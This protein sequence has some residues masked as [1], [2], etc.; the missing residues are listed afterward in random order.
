MA[1]GGKK[2][3]KFGPYELLGR[4]GE[5]GMCHVFRARRREDGR[6]CALKLLKEDQRSDERV[7]DL[8]I[9]EA[10]LSLMLAHP[11]LI[12]TFD[13]GEVDG[14]YYI[15]MELIEGAN[16]DEIARYSRRIGIVFPPDFA[17]YVIN[18]VLDGL[19]ALHDAT[20]KTG[21]P[22]GLVH[23][24]VTPSNVFVCFDGRVIVGDFG[25]AHIMA[26]GDMDR[27][28]A[29]GKLGY[30]APE[31]VTG[32]GI[33]RRADIFAV[34]IIVWELL[35]GQ[36]LFKSEDDDAIMHAIAESTV[37]RIRKLKPGLHKDLEAVVMKSLTKRPRDRWH[38]AEQMRLALEPYWSDLIGHHDA[39]SGFM[40]GLLPEASLKWRQRRPP[41]D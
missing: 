3:V 37:P 35:T 31:V 22:L 13:A 6:M 21:R 8:F 29:V 34:G 20:A 32:D 27:G 12:E 36:R 7:L 15:A 10:D 25:I 14:R 17:L 24:D 16:L 28:Q 1:E 23:R 39:M 18:E 11:N 40:T 38:S 30:L 9:T 2:T 4:L 5:G 19:D 26:Y 33:D 41:T